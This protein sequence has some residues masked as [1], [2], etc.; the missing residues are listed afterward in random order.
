MFKKSNKRIIYY[1]IFEYL[2][3]KIDESTF[4]GEFHFS[5][6]LELNYNELT[7]EE[8]KAFHELVEVSGRFSEYKEDFKKFPGIYYTRE[9]LRQKII[10]TKIKLEKSFDEFVNNIDTEVQDKEFP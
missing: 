9:E 10:E 3:G 1:L 5:Y 7:D 4:C 6:D 2:S 8:Y